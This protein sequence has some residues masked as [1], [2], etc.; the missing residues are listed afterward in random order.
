M[1]PVR[2]RIGLLPYFFGRNPFSNDFR[3]FC[4][5]LG[6]EQ[7]IIDAFLTNI[8]NIN[9]QLLIVKIVLNILTVNLKIKYASA[10]HIQNEI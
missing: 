3:T 4:I 8:Q 10:Y 2:L 9:Y 6:N 7:T 5:I 1:T